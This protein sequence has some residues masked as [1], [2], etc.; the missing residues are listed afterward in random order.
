MISLHF[1]NPPAEGVG[2]VMTTA[3][4][5]DKSINSLYRDRRFHMNSIMP[6]E[7]VLIPHDPR[8]TH[9]KTA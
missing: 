5:V 2:R 8:D 3:P 7:N 9:K 1:T 6:L 4:V